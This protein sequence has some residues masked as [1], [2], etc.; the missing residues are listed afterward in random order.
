MDLQFTYGESGDK[1]MI[2][3]WNNDAVDTIGITR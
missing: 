3:D 1:P 2:G